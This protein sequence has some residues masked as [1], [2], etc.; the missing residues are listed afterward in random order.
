MRR[1]ALLMVLALAAGG[2]DADGKVD[3]ATCKACAGASYSASDCAAWAAEAGCARWEH[4]A[5]VEGCT[6]G[7]SF[8]DC[9]EP[10]RC[11]HTASDSAIPD[12]TPPDLD[13][14]CNTATPGLFPDCDL[15][16]GDCDTVEINGVTSY[17]CGCGA[18]CPCG[19][20]CGSIPLPV[21]GTIGSVCAP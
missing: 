2:C 16:Q 4:L 7:C 15:C 14:S 13:P 11:G 8:E 20:T 21:G 3:S 5:T 12:T 18:P 10:P 9:D 17:A 6:N 19:F 1:A